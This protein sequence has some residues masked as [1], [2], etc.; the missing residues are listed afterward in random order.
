M[1]H[2]TCLRAS[3][4]LA[5]ITLLAGCGLLT[6]EASGG[7]KRITVGT[8]SE[9]TTLD[10]A[11][12]W[13]GSWE[14]YRNVFQTLLSLPTGSTSPQPDAAKSCGFVDAGHRVY[15]CELR[16]GLEFSNGEKLDAAA[17]KHSID[18]IVTIDRRGGPRG[19]LNSLD[20]IEV[21][22]ERTV[23]FRLKSADATFPFILATPA[24]S[25]VLGAHSSLLLRSV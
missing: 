12:A 21:T 25:L 19:L 7:K 15:S 2:R 9:P 5:S 24:T 10:P 16:E 17:V 11:E 8:T 23:R 1:F 14:L 6:D 18:R 22:G 3:A 13:D 4:A 20:R